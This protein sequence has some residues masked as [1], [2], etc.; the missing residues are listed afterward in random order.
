[1]CFISHLTSYRF[2]DFAIGKDVTQRSPGSVSGLKKE[3]L[4]V[5]TREDRLTSDDLAVMSLANR[6]WHHKGDRHVIEALDVE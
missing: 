2:F 4:S 1:M 5:N 3:K 6:S